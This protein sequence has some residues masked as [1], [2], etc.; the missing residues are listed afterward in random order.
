MANAMLSFAAWMA[1]KLP[2]SLKRRLYH[3]GPLSQLMRQTLNRAAPQGLTIIE[4]AAGGLAG[5]NMCLD[6]HSEKDYWLGTYEPELQAAVADLVRPG[7]VAYDVGANIGYISLLLAQAVGE[8]GSVY[9]FEA[10]P[11]NVERLK[12]NLALN[13][14]GARVQVVSAAVVESTRPVHFMVGPSG[15]MGKAQG[16]AGR[17]QTGSAEAIEVHGFSLDQFVLEEKHPTPQV[18]KMDIEGGEVLALPGMQRLLLQS[19]PLI[20]LELHG[21]EAAV[22]TWELLSG[23]GYRLCEMGTGYPTITLVESLDWKAYIVAFP[24][25][26]QEEKS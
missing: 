13:P 11:A 24:P 12:D 10:L 14:A 6:L 2:M 20:L 8:Q 23:A 18:V 15:G 4:M 21:R 16:S 3:L 26:W 7:M 25:G 9:A 17:E 5:F 1:S 22:Q 19:P